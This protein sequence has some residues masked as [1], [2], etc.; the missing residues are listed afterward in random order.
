MISQPQRGP[1]LP[2]ANKYVSGAASAPAGAPPALQSEVEG[3]ALTRGEG[4]NVLG[5]GRDD[6]PGDV[7]QLESKAERLGWCC[8]Q[9]GRHGGQRRPGAVWE[10]A[11]DGD[12]DC[13]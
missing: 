9:V 1:R 13:E 12:L 2:K 5:P 7:D 3:L 8:L 11:E 10:E 6:P 4:G